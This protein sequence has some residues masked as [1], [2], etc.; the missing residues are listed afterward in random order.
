[1]I[2]KLLNVWLFISMIIG[3]YFT[4]KR[5]FKDLVI[6]YAVRSANEATYAFAG[7]IE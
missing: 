6:F 7:D 3:F 2:V 5:K 4:F 1:M